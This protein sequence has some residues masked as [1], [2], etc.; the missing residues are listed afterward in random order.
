M[1]NLNGRQEA[2]RGGAAPDAH[3]ANRSRSPYRSP[4]STVA[5]PSFFPSDDDAPNQPFPR[6]PR[7]GFVGGLRGQ[8][9]D[10]AAAVLAD[11]HGSGDRDGAGVR[12]EDGRGAGALPGF[13]MAGVRAG[14][15]R[16]DG[17]SLG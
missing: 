7:D 6:A 1:V 12:P 8:P 3:I 11:R 10:R 17:P 5:F 2:R 9:G 14:P 4:L 16:A 13:G 15:G